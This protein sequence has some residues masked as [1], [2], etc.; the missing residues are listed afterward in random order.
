M[1]AR[2]LRR[3][4]IGHH[5]PDG[6]LQAQQL[7]RD[8][9]Q[10]R[11][12]AI[13]PLGA[14]RDAAGDV[15]QLS[16]GVRLVERVDHGL[17]LRAQRGE[18]VAHDVA[19]RIDLFGGGVGHDDQQIRQRGL[20][21]R[22]T[23]RV[24]ERVRQLADEADRVHEQ[25]LPALR[26]AHAARDGIERREELVLGHDARLG[27]PVEQRGLAGVRIAHQRHDGHGV[28][29]APRAPDRALRAQVVDLAAQVGHALADAPPVHLQARLAR[30]A[31]ADAA[32]Q[33]GHGQAVADQARQL[34]VHLRQ[35]HLQPALT[36][37]R[38]LGEDVQDERRAVHDLD[39][40]DVLQVAGLRA[41][42]LVV[43]DRQVDVQRLAV[44][45]DLLG[46]AA[47]HIRRALSPRAALQHAAHHFGASCLRQPRKLLQRG[48]A[49]QAHQIRTLRSARLRRGLALQDARI[50]AQ[51]LLHPHA[52][53]D[54]IGAD[55]VRHLLLRHARL[56]L[57]QEGS[58]YAGGLAV[59]RAHGRHR[60][61]AQRA[62]GADVHI[63]QTR[64][65]ARMGVNAADHRQ[66]AGVSP[67]VHVLERHALQPADGHIQHLAAA[68]DVNADLPVDQACVARKALE[69]VH[70]R[71]LALL[72]R[73]LIERLDLGE[74]RIANALCI[75]V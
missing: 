66:A 51:D 28:A 65:P 72:D 2:Q 50:R 63:R 19:L 54:A 38:A 37:L 24:D 64:I 14:D 69:Q 74:Q 52:L 22:G 12:D 59:P 17:V 18:H 31:R 29:L 57:A 43:K 15:G 55:D 56:A 35:L 10:Q 49:V 45:G 32:A 62:Q 8:G 7:R 34:V 41:R 60:V 40:Q 46:L 5:Q 3:A 53:R 61:K 23:E 71:E 27:Q 21:Q 26:R 33:A 73:R 42:Q 39:A 58:L 13:P 47:A 16:G 4:R 20:L 67:Q 11:V 75:S 30:A 6:P 48:L 25:E 44:Q 68:G 70:R 1:Q 9:L 36:R